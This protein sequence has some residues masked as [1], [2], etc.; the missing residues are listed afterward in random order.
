MLTWQSPRE[1]SS[2]AHG[3][4]T[5]ICVAFCLLATTSVGI[6]GRER[7]DCVEEKAKIR[8]LCIKTNCLLWGDYPAIRTSIK[9]ARRR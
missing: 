8:V 9:E 5:G 4:A 1:V 7:N 2:V 3:G 6:C